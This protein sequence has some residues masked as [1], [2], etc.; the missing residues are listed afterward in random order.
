MNPNLALIGKPGSRYRLSTPA[1]VL[2]L[3]ALQRNIARMAALATSHGIGLRP[4][5]KSH[6]SIEIA[7][8]QAQAGVRGISCATLGEAE[9]MV[10][11]GLPGVLITSPVVGADK[12]RRLIESGRKAGPGQLMVV[13]DHPGNVQELAAQAKL[14]GYRLPV[15]VDYHAGLHRTGVTDTAAAV[16]LAQQI[17]DSDSLLLQGLQAYGGHL[18]H[19]YDPQQREQAAANLCKDVKAVVAAIEAAGMPLNIVTGVGTGTHAFDAAAGVFTEMQPGSYLFMDSD[20]L[21]AMSDA[22][23]PAPFET[24][25]FVQ[26]TVVSVNADEW[27]AVDAGLKSLA[28]DSG[29]PEVAYGVQGTTHY[30]F[31]GDEHGKLIVATPHRPALGDHIEFVTSHCDPTVNLHNFYHLVD[32][33]TLVDIWPI[34]ARGRI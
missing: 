33:D 30:E 12:L 7:R 20:Y 27:V 24:A 18:Q 4:H 22:S 1:L 25:L 23:H 34:Q 13:A 2:D 15:L 32:G 3:P 16:A 21:R 6:K 9:V 10:E 26:S 28:T 17:A 8:L 19:I 29:T 11:A 31:F 5:A 14:L